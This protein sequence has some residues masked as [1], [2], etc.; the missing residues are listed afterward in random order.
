[1]EPDEL[2]EGERI[3]SNPGNKICKICRALITDE[4]L[5]RN[6]CQNRHLKCSWKKN[7]AREERPVRVIKSQKRRFKQ[8]R[9]DTPSFHGD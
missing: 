8:L 5:V 9:D 3:I 7:K 6:S 4:T 2:R 1:M